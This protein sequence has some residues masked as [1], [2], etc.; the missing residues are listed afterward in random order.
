MILANIYSGLVRQPC[1]MAGTIKKSFA[2]RLTFF[3]I[4]SP[5]YWTNANPAFR[6]ATLP[7]GY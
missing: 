4:V 7:G 3:S 6:L 5:N 1:C 2:L